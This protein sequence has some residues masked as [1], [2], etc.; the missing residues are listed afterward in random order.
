[1]ELINCIGINLP[2]ASNKYQKE[3]SEVRNKSIHTGAVVSQKEAE[4]AFQIVKETL[5][6]LIKDKLIKE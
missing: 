2:L 3:V 6:E 5:R 4:K 1:M